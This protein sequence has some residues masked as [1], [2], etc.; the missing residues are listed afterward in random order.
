MLASTE[1]EFIPGGENCPANDFGLSCIGFLGV[2]PDGVAECIGATAQEVAESVAL[3]RAFPKGKAPPE[4]GRADDIAS[5]G[6]VVP[7]CIR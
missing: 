3:K 4:L 1:C 7:A 2:I 6:Q 5:G